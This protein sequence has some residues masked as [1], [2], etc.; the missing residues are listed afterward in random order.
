M[1]SSGSKNTLKFLRHPPN[2]GSNSE[3]DD[4]GDD[5]ELD[6]TVE[7]GYPATKWLTN[8]EFV[9]HFKQSDLHK[10]VL[11]VIENLNSN[12][13]KGD[14]AQEVRSYLCT[15]SCYIRRTYR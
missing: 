9:E 2:E 11:E 6:K 1:E 12:P 4:D 14:L 3:D 7:D 8:T 5:E 10:H 15:F 13:G